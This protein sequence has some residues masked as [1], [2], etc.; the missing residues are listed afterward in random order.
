MKQFA[1]AVRDYTRAIEKSPE[2][3]PESYIERSKTVIAQG[4]DHTEE[5]LRGLD[6]GIRKLGP[7]V[8]LQ[9]PAI[10]LE[11][12]RKNFDAALERI[13]TLAAQ[14]ERKESW[15]LQRGQILR[16]AGRKEK[17][18]EAFRDALTAWQSLPENIRETKAGQQLGQQI[19][20]ELSAQ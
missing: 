15:L 19:R 3:E 10:E 2:P 13:D 11:L 4:D 12:R 8:T 20:S 16:L 5:A 9:L 17:A 7:I 1:E 6:E 18:Q 14:S